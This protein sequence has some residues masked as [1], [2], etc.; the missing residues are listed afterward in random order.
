MMWMLWVLWGCS[1]DCPTPDP[2][3]PG[4]VACDVLPADEGCPRVLLCCDDAATCWV[5]TADETAD[6][7]PV[8]CLEALDLVCGVASE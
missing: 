6:C 1:E 8:D 7:G 5:E 4:P 2:V 3:D